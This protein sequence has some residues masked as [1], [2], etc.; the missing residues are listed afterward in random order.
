[1]AAFREAASRDNDSVAPLEY[2]DEIIMS[3]GS[4]SVVQSQR[5]FNHGRIKSVEIIDQLSPLEMED[6]DE[7]S[8]CVNHI[9]DLYSLKQPLNSDLFEEIE[10]HYRDLHPLKSSIKEDERKQ[11]RKLIYDLINEALAFINER[12]Y[13]KVLSFKSQ[14]HPAHKDQHLLDK[15]R[16][17]VG[18]SLNW[19]PNLDNLLESSIDESNWSGGW[20]NLQTE[21]EC[22]ALELEDLILDE[23]LDENTTLLII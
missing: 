16:A 12:Q 4:E 1:M 15:I 3:G 8:L 6:D 9:L 18:R 23:L 2:G 11:D 22:T 5:A 17:F 7:Y 19:I 10:T 21:S 13:L 20:M 14:L